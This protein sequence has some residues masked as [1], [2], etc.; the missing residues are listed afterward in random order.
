MRGGALSRRPRGDDGRGQSTS[1]SALGLR[2]SLVFSE[3]TN[4]VFVWAR[5][6]RPYTSRVTRLT[7][8][9]LSALLLAR[10]C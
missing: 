3:T 9:V 1:A 10:L 7:R 8:V 4:T 2:T 5:A 6:L